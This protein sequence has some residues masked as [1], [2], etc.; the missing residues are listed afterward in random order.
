MMQALAF[1]KTMTEHQLDV[2]L[3]INSGMQASWQLISMLTVPMGY[4]QPVNHRYYIHK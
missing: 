1:E 4:T 3:S 2:I